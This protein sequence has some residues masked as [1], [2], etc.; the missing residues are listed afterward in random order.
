VVSID[1]V[2]LHRCV[3]HDLWD[4]FEE[5]LEATIEQS[6][7]VADGVSILLYSAVVAGASANVQWLMRIEPEINPDW[8]ITVCLW[9]GRLECVQ[10]LQEWGMHLQLHDVMSSVLWLG[11]KECVEWV[12]KWLPSS[13]RLSCTA[14]AAAAEGGTVWALEWCHR[15]P[16]MH[17]RGTAWRR[18]S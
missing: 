4:T 9:H 18:R 3:E 10:L 14:W 5:F 15:L 6:G 13:V 1:N 17:H 12:D 11:C 8:V 7:G 16:W 2:V